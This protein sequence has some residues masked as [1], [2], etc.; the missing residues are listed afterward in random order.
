MPQPPADSDSVTADPSPPLLR[1]PGCDSAHRDAQI[2]IIE[3]TCGLALSSSA[4]IAFGAAR[5]ARAAAPQVPGTRPAAAMEHRRV[6]MSPLVMVMMVGLVVPFTNAAAAVMATPLGAT[7]Y[8]AEILDQVNIM[9]QLLSNMTIELSKATPDPTGAPPDEETEPD[10]PDNLKLDHPMDTLELLPHGKAFDKRSAQWLPELP[11]TLNLQREENLQSET[12]ACHKNDVSTTLNGSVAVLDRVSAREFTPD[13]LAD[14]KA[15]NDALDT[16]FTKCSLSAMDY[17]EAQ[18]LL[19]SVAA[20]ETH[21]TAAKAA[22]TPA[23]VGLEVGSA[24]MVVLI[25]LSCLMAVAA[26]VGLAVVGY[27]Y[28]TVTARPSARPTKGGGGP[29]IPADRVRPDAGRPNP[30]YE[31]ADPP[32]SLHQARNERWRQDGEV[33]PHRPAAS[34]STWGRIWGGV[35]RDYQR[36]RDSY[37]EPRRASPP[38]RRASPPPRRASPPPR[39][40]SPPPRRASPPPRR[41]SPPPRRYSPPP[42]P[43]SGDNWAYGPSGR[44]KSTDSPFASAW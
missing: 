40:A 24:F 35:V 6:T 14:M 19:G 34:K 42:Q 28:A 8:Q 22:A 5:P 17:A 37:A 36:A 38:P 43:E 3:I 18:E 9:D 4:T 2:I 25:T 41:A 10:G 44:N 39:R 32:G 16:F 13:V 11:K 15:Q 27:R 26:M 33:T 21:V 29:T 7:D 23:E 30:A 12:N 31:P 1:P 20:T